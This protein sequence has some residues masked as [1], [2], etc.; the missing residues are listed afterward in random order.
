[1]D[2]EK[3]IDG[4]KTK[5]EFADF[6]CGLKEDL[7]LNS[8]EWE[9]PTLERFLDAMEAWIRAMDFYAINSGGEEVLVPSWQTFAKI[10]FASKIYE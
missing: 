7:E 6:I 1:M 3:M 5:E 9:N 4:I 2:F 8:N 10:L